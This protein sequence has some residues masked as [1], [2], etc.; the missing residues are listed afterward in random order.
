LLLRAVR[1]PV[2]V[3]ATHETDY[4]VEAGDPAVDVTPADTGDR[5]EV[6]ASHRDR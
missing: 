2:G 1:A 6:T 3:D 5:G 4:P